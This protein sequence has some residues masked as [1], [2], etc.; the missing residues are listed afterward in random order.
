MHIDVVLY[1][2]TVLQVQ[3]KKGTTLSLCLKKSEIKRSHQIYGQLEMLYEA[4][5]V[6]SSSLSY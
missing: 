5:Y 4:F 1:T 3:I 2:K 6:S